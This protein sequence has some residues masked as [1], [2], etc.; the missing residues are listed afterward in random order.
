MS[1]IGKNFLGFSRI[2]RRFVKGFSIISSPLTKLLKKVVKFICDEK[3][4]QNFK[5]LKSLMI[6]AP[7]L[8]LPIDMGKNMWCTLILLTMV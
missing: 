6:Q 8:T 7:V 1:D 2:L 5:T 4:Q 3:C